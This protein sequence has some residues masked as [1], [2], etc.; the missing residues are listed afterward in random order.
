MKRGFSGQRPQR[1]TR[2]HLPGDA[3]PAGG[4]EMSSLLDRVLESEEEEEEAGV[5]CG[6]PGG[7]WTF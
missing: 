7:P 3:P 5:S 4:T 6:A 2:V 1:E